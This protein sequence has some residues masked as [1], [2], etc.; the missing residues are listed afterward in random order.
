MRK[1]SPKSGGRYGFLPLPG[2]ALYSL[3]E[4]LPTLTEVAQVCS[5][6]MSETGHSVSSVERALDM[7]PIS[8]ICVL[9][10]SSH[11]NCSDHSAFAYSSPQ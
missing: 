4:I 9:L 8:K 2:R 7:V 11:Y 3:V 6:P 5:P 10:Q 1:R